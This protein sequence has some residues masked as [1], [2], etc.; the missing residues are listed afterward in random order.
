MYYDRLMAIGEDFDNVV[1]TETLKKSLLRGNYC[2]YNELTDSAYATK[3][4]YAVDYS[5]GD[6]LFIHG[7]TLMMVSYNVNTDS[8]IREMRD[9]H[10]VRI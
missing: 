9:Y 7:E 2:Y 8:L 4:A 1:M 5:Q 3:R 6:S 10:K